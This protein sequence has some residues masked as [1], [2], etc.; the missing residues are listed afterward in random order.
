MQLFQYEGAVESVVFSQ[1]DTFEQILW[2]STNQQKQVMLTTTGG[3]VYVGFATSTADPHSQRDYV[4]LMKM[5]SGYRDEETNKLH[6]TTDYGPIIGAISDAPEAFG[7][8]AATDFNI[9]VPI[10]EVATMNIFDP[11]VYEAYW[12]GKPD[13]ERLR[14]LKSDD[15]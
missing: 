14:Q 4:R 2:V 5:Q 15:A 6:L 1:G 11:D 10:S 9:V 13:L 8:L 12:D 3:K 7:N